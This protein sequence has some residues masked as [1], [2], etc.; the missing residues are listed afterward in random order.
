VSYFN[1]VKQACDPPLFILQI[2]MFV[3]QRC[4]RHCVFNAGE[5]GQVMA[6]MTSVPVAVY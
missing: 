4:L 6:V 2:T 5:A 3:K 1:F